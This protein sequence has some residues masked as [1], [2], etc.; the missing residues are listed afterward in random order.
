MCISETP[1]RA[2]GRFDPLSAVAFSQV[3]CAA[4]AK[5]YVVVINTRPAGWIFQKSLIGKCGPVESG[6]AGAISNVVSGASDQDKIIGPVNATDPYSDDE[7]RD[8]T[9]G[10]L[11]KLGFEAAGNWN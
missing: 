9:I 3:T 5:S 1:E 8:C 7:R 11:A 10:G 2:G 4:P 6:R